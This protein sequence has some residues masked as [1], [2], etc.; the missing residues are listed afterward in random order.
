MPNF[1]DLRFDEN[2]TYNVTQTTGDKLGTRDTLV[3]LDIAPND[4]F[5]F[6]CSQTTLYFISP[7]LKV[8]DKV[9]VKDMRTLKKLP[10]IKGKLW[11]VLPKLPK[12]V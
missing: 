3:D 8:L 6:V 2:E 10:A 9:A 4:R 12:I 7:A 5:I 11:I 1:I